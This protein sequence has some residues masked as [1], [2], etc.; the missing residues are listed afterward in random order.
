MLIIKRMKFYVKHVIFNTNSKKVAQFAKQTSFMQNK[1]QD[2]DTYGPGIN[3]DR[4]A[5][6]KQKI[7]LHTSL[8][9]FLSLQ[10]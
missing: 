2:D 5:L 8:L 6:V 4:V 9:G 3:I 10:S 7:K 1:N